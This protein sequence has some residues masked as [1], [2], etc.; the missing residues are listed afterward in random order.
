MMT[1]TATKKKASAETILTFPT[2]WSLQ[3]SGEINLG[4]LDGPLDHIHFTIQE[5]G[6]VDYIFGSVD[7]ILL[8]ALSFP[9]VGMVKDGRM[10]FILPTEDSVF[11][12]TGQM[13]IVDNQLKIPH[14]AIRQLHLNPQNQARK[15]TDDFE[16]GSWSATAQ[17]PPPTEELIRR[18][19]L[20]RVKRTS[21]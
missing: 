15:K 5:A 12:F 3:I 4:I 2:T 18:Y 19:H 11:T 14:G 7:N 16:E 8:P 20:K 1:A 17:G 10:S 21:R 13:E 9:V 6:D